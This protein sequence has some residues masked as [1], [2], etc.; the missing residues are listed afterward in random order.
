MIKVKCIV[1][2]KGYKSFESKVQKMKFDSVETDGDFI[3]LCDG[4]FRVKLHRT[5]FAVYSTL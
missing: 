4:G 5:Y 3:Y 2:Q 1:P